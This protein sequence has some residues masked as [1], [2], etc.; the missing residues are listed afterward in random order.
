MKYGYNNKNAFIDNSEEC[1]YFLGFISAGGSLND[2]RNSLR[3]N[4]NEKD[5][6]VLIMLKEYL[7]TQK[8]IYNLKQ[9][10]SVLFEIINSDI[11]NRLKYYGL[12]PKKSLTNKFPKNIPNDMLH[13]FIRGYFDGDGCVSVCKGVNTLRL[14]INFVGTFEFLSE[15]QNILVKSADIT[16]T[17]ITNMTKDKNTFQLNIKKKSDIKKIETY[18]YYHS[19]FFLKRKKKI[20][21]TNIDHKIEYKK[22]SSQY[23]NVFF[24]KKTQ[25]WGISFYKNNKRHEI[26]GFLTEFDAYQKLQEIKNGYIYTHSQPCD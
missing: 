15:L 18:L 23:R 11:Y 14:K 24:R 19:N 7:K 8:P 22:T 3:I 12:T 17:K 6:E 16:I 13:H 5:I 9:T 25:K 1:F 26:F 20:F 10:N 2:D 4:I 21:E